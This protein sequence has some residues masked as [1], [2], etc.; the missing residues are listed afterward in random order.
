MYNFEEDKIL[1]WLKREKVKDVLVQ[2]PDGI[3]SQIRRLVD[4]LE[5]K[6]Y[7]VYISSSHTWGGC[8][9]A[10]DEAKALN[11]HH[12]VHIGHHGPVRIRDYYNIKVLFIPGYSDVSIDNLMGNLVDY[13]RERY[14]RI[15]LFTVIQHYDKFEYM[16]NMLSKNGINV[17]TGQSPDSYLPEGVII[18]CDV[19]AAG[20]IEGMVDAI[21]VIAGGVFHAIGVALYCEKP[22]ISAD[23]Y[24]G[25]IRLMDNELRKIYTRRLDNIMRALDKE[26]FI[27]ATSTKPGQFFVSQVRE[28]EREL[29]KA[30]KKVIKII[31]N[32]INRDIFLNFEGSSY[33]YVNA[34]CPRLGID[35]QE[36]FPGPVVNIGEVKYII[37]K[38]MEE[39]SLKDALSLD[40]VARV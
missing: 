31:G 40:V 9:L 3:K 26:N 35:D 38:K 17:L 39:Y 27:I 34:A 20:L 28:I 2:A 24:T 4:Y 22:V 11:I 19:R 21:V 18:G 25:K 6:Q 12:I 13:L 36:I 16:K 7:N 29:R 37:G 1:A 32:E 23:P 14:D 8:D 30:G 5:E 15:G 33:G 10:F